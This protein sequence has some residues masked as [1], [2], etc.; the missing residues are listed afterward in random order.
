MKREA[1]AKKL[2]VLGID[3]MDPRFTKVMLE[4]NKMPNLKKIIEKGSAREDLTMLGGHPTITPPMWTTLSTGAYPCT[5]GITCFFRQTDEGLDLLEYNLDSTKC[6]AEALW[7]VF[8]EAGKKTLVWHWPG[9]SWPPTSDSPNLH[10]V[11]GTSPGSV[12]MSIAHL[13]GEIVLV[14]SPNV[15]EPLFRAKAACDTNVPCVITDA[16]VSN[17]KGKDDMAQID[18]PVMK[19]L[20]VFPEDGKEGGTDAPFDA[21][22]SPIIDPK[23]W[24]NAP[25][26]AKEFYAMFA[27]GL[28]RRPCLLLKNDAGVYDRI[29]LYK[30]KKDKEPIVVAAKG[31]YVRD[32]FD[33]GINRQGTRCKVNRNLRVLE[34]KED[35]SYVKIWFS[36]AMESE[37]DSLWHPKELY[38]KVTQN[39]GYPTPTSM[40]GGADRQL[41][42]D[43][44][45]ESWNATG[46]WQS[47]SIN[48]L[49]EEEK[50]DVVFSHFHNIDLQSHMV[51]AFL[52][53]GHGNLKPEDYV[54]FYE[55]M[56]L[57]TDEYLSKFMYLLDEGWTIFIVSDHALVCAENKSPYLGDPTGISV[58][59]MRDLGLTAVKTDE[60]GNLLHEIDWE[61][62][63]AIAQR[64]NHIYVNLKGRDKNGIIDPKDKYQV[65]EEIM[66]ALYGYKHPETGQ[67]VIALALRN[68]DAYILGMGG[69]ECGDIIYFKAEGY[70]YDHGDN[71]STCYGVQNT[72]VS[73]IF[74]AAGPGIKENYV[75]DRIVREVDLAPT[76][77]VLGGVRMPKQCEGAPV[78]QILTEEF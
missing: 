64:A 66:T 36:A 16:E 29:A 69:P 44:M 46:D 70:T 13:E 4:K 77:A 42:H 8:A 38:K 21:A 6:H 52:K 74:I 60:N 10:V 20:I 72:S 47:A 26:G 24:E 51:A 1:L 56:Y 75:T 14:A 55:D 65:E 7:N 2:L 33:E 19:N 15:E 73:P 28:I 11:D 40:V 58:G 59:F 68:K 71:L 22:V 12:N 61:N 39:V 37:N 5:H 3:G 78:Y 76:M 41:I 63:K 23:G 34:L 54:G 57:Q 50:Y 9:S 17:A 48:Y 67:R 53:D 25:E 45:F 35:G 43:C 18:S 30:S 31:Q 27:G 32:I 62:T 49:I